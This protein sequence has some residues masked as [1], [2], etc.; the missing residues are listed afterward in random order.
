MAGESRDGR[1]EI[2]NNAAAIR[3]IAL[4]RK[5]WLFSRAATGPPPSTP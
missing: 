4:G 3:A 2:D 1:L 5:N